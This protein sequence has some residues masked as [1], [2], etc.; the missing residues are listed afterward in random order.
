M[1]SV[2][3]QPLDSEAVRLTGSMVLPLCQL[4]DERIGELHKTVHE[5]VAALPRSE[6]DAMAIIEVADAPQ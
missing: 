2:P 1:T 6:R 5:K 4:I 3:A